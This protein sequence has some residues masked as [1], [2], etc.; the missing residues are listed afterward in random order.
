[1]A[2]ILRTE[3]GEMLLLPPPSRK[4]TDVCGLRVEVDLLTRSLS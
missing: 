2:A 3:L 4:L 1:M